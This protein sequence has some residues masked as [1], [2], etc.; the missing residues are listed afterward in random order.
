MGKNSREGQ[1]LHVS[2]F[3]FA[4]SDPLVLHWFASPSILPLCFV[5]CQ[6]FLTSSFCGFS[7][8]FLWIW[9]LLFLVAGVLRGIQI[10]IYVG[11]SLC[12]WTNLKP[13]SMWK[14][15]AHVYAPGGT[16]KWLTVFFFCEPV[17]NRQIFVPGFSGPVKTASI[18]KHSNCLM[19]FLGAR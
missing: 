9:S 4:T 2:S 17:N 6:S 7:T 3:S 16:Q 15:W 11:L 14:R 5:F 10:Y 1:I 13:N 18:Q 8:S 19:G 12:C